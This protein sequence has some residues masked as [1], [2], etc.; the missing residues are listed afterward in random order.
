VI[1]DFCCSAVATAT[2][3]CCC[4]WDEFKFL[5]SCRGGVIKSAREHFISDGYF[6]GRL[7]FEM[8]VDET[9]YLDQNPDVA[10]IHRPRR[11]EFCATALHAKWLAGRQDAQGAARISH[12][13]NARHAVTPMSSEL[14]V[15]R[16]PSV[17]CCHGLL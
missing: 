3:A 16:F 9:W 10:G 7:P 12:R 15:V 13:A 8:K 5:T 1:A 14:L 4:V 11:S 17:Y 2:V 6:E